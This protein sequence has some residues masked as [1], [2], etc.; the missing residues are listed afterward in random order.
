MV[1]KS[2]EEYLEIIYRITEKGEK[3]TTTNISKLL[4]VASSSV[5]EM[6]QRLRN[7][8]YIEYEPYGD[9]VLTKK[10]KAL[11]EK[12]VRK[13]RILEKFL[14]SIGLKKN[15]HSEACRLEHAISDDVE[16]AIDKSIGYPEKSP[17]GMEIPRDEKGKRVIFLINL[18]PGEKGKITK[19]I[20]GKKA[21]KRLMDMGLTTNTKII[22]INSQQNCPIEI[23]V[24]GSR[25]SIGR[26]LASKIVVE[27]EE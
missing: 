10:G 4:N 1:T 17:T 3:V 13:H 23:C 2:I 25:L 21:T 12:I 19:I 20:S 27:R 26:G 6:L 5:T 7:E 24:R 18:K 9:I 14:E 22:V 15:L 8:G 11:G 16:R